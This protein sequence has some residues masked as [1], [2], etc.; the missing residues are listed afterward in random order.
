MSEEEGTMTLVRVNESESGGDFV[1][2]NLRAVARVECHGFDGE[3]ARHRAAIF[4]SG[5]N[6]QLAGADADRVIAALE[7]FAGQPSL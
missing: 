6:V 2:L 5:G 1:L 3:Q 4:T 7:D